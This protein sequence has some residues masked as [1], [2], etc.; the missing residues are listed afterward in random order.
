MEV[1]RT[2]TIWA[3]SPIREHGDLGGCLSFS[4]IRG[5]YYAE[6]V[7]WKNICGEPASEHCL[8][9]FNHCGGKRC[10]L[11]HH[12]WYVSFRVLATSEDAGT[13]GRPHYTP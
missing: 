3:G 9:R 1:A 4:D 5:R 12:D 2:R 7:R 10:D 8:Q 11:C 13:T 6:G